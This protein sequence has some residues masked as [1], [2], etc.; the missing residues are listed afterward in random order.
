MPPNLKKNSMHGAVQIIGAK[1]VSM[2][3][4]H[5]IDCLEYTVQVKLVRDLVLRDEYF[6]SDP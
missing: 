6:L 3:I 5:F 4:C 2:R 1:I